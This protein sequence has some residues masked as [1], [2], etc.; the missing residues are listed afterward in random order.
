[1]RD[2][3]PDSGG[4]AALD[5]TSVRREDATLHVVRGGPADGGAP[6]LF[7]HGYP[8]TWVTW[9]LQMEA[10]A[11]TRP[12][13]AFDQRGVG[14]STGPATREGYAYARHLADIEAVIDEVA[15]P[16]GQV[17]LVAHDWGGGLAWMFAERP[18][19]ARRL[20]SLT[21][22]SCPHPALMMRRLGRVFRK[23]SLRE[24]GL[25]LDQLR[26]SWYILF[27]QLPRV[28]EWYVERQFPGGRIRAL[29]AG[30]VPA[31][32]PMLHD[33]DVE[34]LRRAAIAPLALYRQALRTKAP[35]PVPI[36]VP[37][38]LI[39][40]VHDFALRPELYDEVPTLVRDLEVHSL[41]AN[42]WVQ[43]QRPAEVTAI[44]EAFLARHA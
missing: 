31:D 19:Y 5:P 16:E 27:F 9:S 23:P 22:A 20:R 35:A 6:V 29:C 39:V 8:D 3:S 44:L 37:T 11:R 2:D 15:G 33:P 18:E 42:H 34:G 26:R 41:D 25:T 21:V 10:L 36:D 7:L 43:R 12:V 28:P 1:M 14:G 40:P 30:G 24:L 38:C 4:R 17:H 13:A 32:D